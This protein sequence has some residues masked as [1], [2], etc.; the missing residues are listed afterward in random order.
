MFAGKAFTECD[1]P[2]GD[3]WTVFALGLA[4]ESKQRGRSD[5]DGP[6]LID[7]SDMA[8]PPLKDGGRN[9]RTDFSRFSR[10]YFGE[11]DTCFLRPR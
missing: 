10:H 7:E 3:F 5:P 6:E 9:Y 8:A 2:T 1:G 11:D 4:G